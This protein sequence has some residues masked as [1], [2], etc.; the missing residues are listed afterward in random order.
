M[1]FDV[2]F[3]L[4]SIDVVDLLLLLICSCRMFVGSSRLFWCLVGV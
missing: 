1:P 4:D 3:S 2:S